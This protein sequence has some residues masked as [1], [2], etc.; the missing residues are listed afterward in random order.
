MSSPPLISII[1][2]VYN[3][4][5]HLREQMD[6][7]WAQRCDFPWEAIYVDN[8]SRDGSRT[9]I[10]QR[11]AE[12]GVSHIRV[13][14]GSQAQGQV[15]AR[16]CGVQAA[17]A[18]L[19]AFTDQDDLPAPDWVA[20]MAAALEKSAAVAG[21][22]VRTPDGYPPAAN[23]NTSPAHEKP[24]L[25]WNGIDCAIG[26]NFGIH[27]QVLAAVGGWQDIK[28]HAGEDIDLSLRLHY[29][30]HRIAYAPDARV[31]WRSRMRVGDIWS[32]AFTYG[33]G[34][35]QLYQRHRAR[36]PRLRTKRE[37]LRT[38]RQAFSSLCRIFD[39]P[40]SYLWV[41]LWG[42]MAG[43]LYESIRTRTLYF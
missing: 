20:A 12:T 36:L 15:Y 23:R 32:Q 1:I 26:S 40:P 38:V 35:V 4:S 2:A 29:A 41:H 6:A 11:I 42:R 33:R 24:Q 37:M 17:R 13:I 14:D 3:G 34:N 10:E 9:M 22:I 30:G 39:Q 16:N 18:D 5:A 31:T 7:L 28:V 19:L 25:R 21:F 27:R 43:E 8:G